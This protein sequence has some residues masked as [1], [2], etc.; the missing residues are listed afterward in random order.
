MFLGTKNIIFITFLALAGSGTAA[1]NLVLDTDK[2][3]SNYTHAKETTNGITVIEESTC[4]L[5][6]PEPLLRDLKKEGIV[7]SLKPYEKVKVIE[8]FYIDNRELFSN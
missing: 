4:E 7:R 1:L 8:N 2:F 5:D 6:K 3:M